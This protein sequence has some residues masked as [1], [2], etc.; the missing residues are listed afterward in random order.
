MKIEFQPTNNVT[1]GTPSAD[2]ADAFTI[3]LYPLRCDEAG[4]IITQAWRNNGYCT[5]LGF[6][7]NMEEREDI[8]LFK[9]AVKNPVE[10]LGSHFIIADDNKDILT[11]FFVAETANIDGTIY[12]TKE[13]AH[14]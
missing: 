5:I 3:Q 11:T 2:L 10:V 7:K 6:A 14:G 12:Q 9:D 8:I 1:M 13:L 4:N